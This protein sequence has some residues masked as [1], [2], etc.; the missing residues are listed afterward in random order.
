MS[1][2]DLHKLYGLVSRDGCP[3]FG[4]WF[5]PFTL[6]S[7][8][9]SPIA[10]FV[11]TNHWL[12]PM[13]PLPKVVGLVILPGLSAVTQDGMQTHSSASIELF[14]LRWRSQQEQEVEVQYLLAPGSADDII[15]GIVKRKL[16][17]VGSALDGHLAGTA[18]GA[19]ALCSNPRRVL[20]GTC[21]SLSCGR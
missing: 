5:L 21:R 13:I 9:T 20:P 11:C 2:L 6:S 17:V 19:P 12:V 18:T 1:I 15:W 4:V 7:C 16:Q 8:C 14:L 10:Q 3:C